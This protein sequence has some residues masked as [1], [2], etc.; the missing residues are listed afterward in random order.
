MK[1]KKLFLSLIVVVGLIA[2]ILTVQATLGSVAGVYTPSQLVRDAGRSKTIHRVRIAGR[3]SD[4]PIS[5]I[6]EP[7]IELRFSVVDRENPTDKLLVV[8]RNLKPDMFAAGRDV[9]ID[10]D[11][12]EGVLE[13]SS[14]LT[15]CPSKYEP[16]SLTEGGSAQYRG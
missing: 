5:Y 13:A 8:Y 7:S 4:D 2:L 11:F 9:L 16:P 12:I 10:G 3:V 15:Q 14:L 1:Q 6:V